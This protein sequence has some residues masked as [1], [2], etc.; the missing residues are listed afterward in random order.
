MRRK[1]IKFPLK[2]H[3][4]R[5]KRLTPLSKLS[6]VHLPCSTQQLNP[7]CRAAWVCELLRVRFERRKRGERRGK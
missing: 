6:G 5:R 1:E 2:I 3:L 4:L 7:A